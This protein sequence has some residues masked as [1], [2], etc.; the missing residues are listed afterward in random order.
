LRSIVVPVSSILLLWPVARA[1]AQDGDAD[2]VVD[3]RDNC[4]V[5]ANPTQLDTNRDGFGN[6]CDTDYDDNGASGATDF[7]IFKAAYL[8]GLGDPNYDPEV[9]AD[10]NGAIGASDFGVFKA[11]YLHFPGPSGLGCAATP[12]CACDAPVLDTADAATTGDVTLGWRADAGFEYAVERRQEG[13]GGAQWGAWTTLAT[14]AT[15]EATYIDASPQPDFYEYRMRANCSASSGSPHWSE[16][17]NVVAV[18]L[19]DECD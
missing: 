3:K 5:V 19:P 1:I 17:S 2:G 18:E 13:V 7:G 16:Y 8:S 14:L 4:V 11:Y 9:D 6:L 12:P 15:S 10:G